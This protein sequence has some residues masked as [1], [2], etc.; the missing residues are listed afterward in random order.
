MSTHRQIIERLVAAQDSV[1][2]K[3]Y[4]NPRLERIDETGLSRIL[5]YHQD[6]GYILVSAYR[7]AKAEGTDPEIQKSKNLKNDSELRHRLKAKK[8]S[9]IPVYGG[10]KEETPEGKVDVVE[11]SYLVTF[12][13]AASSPAS[14][15]T[16][17]DLKNFGV[18]LAKDYNQDSI[19]L[20]EPGPNGMGHFVN[21]NGQIEASFNSVKVNDAT[22]AYF[23]KLFKDVWGSKRN[24]P[25][26]QRKTD[27]RFTYVESLFR[28]KSP[29]DVQE[30]CARYGENPF[31]NDTFFS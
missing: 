21:K 18:E 8:L 5:S 3:Y 19:F 20:K 17:E 13:D 7:S 11:P 1:S 31:F 12:R 27:K 6:K 9:F 22:Q 25:L 26:D 4:Q 23:T 30:A 28:M 16:L 15:G 2:N 29:S 14:Q 24:L 10:F